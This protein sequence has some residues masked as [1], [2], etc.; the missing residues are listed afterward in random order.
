MAPDPSLAKAWKDVNIKKPLRT[1]PPCIHNTGHAR[2]RGKVYKGQMNTTK[3][4]HMW[5]GKNDVGQII[6]NNVALCACG[7][8]ISQPSTNNILTI[9]TLKATHRITSI[10]KIL[11]RTKIMPATIPTARH[12]LI[13]LIV[14]VFLVQMWLVLPH[15]CAGVKLTSKSS[16]GNCSMSLRT[17]LRICVFLCTS[18]FS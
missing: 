16:R 18:T 9:T 5:E 3:R 13:K 12:V 2:A 15:E 11:L 10:V 4:T 7:F 17:S 14:L 1:T 6:I 8:G